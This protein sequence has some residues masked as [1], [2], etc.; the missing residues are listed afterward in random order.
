MKELTGLSEV[1]E[2]K[3]RV[4]RRSHGVS[5]GRTRSLCHFFFFFLF[6][7]LFFF[8]LFLLLNKCEGG[9][10]RLRSRRVLAG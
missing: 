7:F 5:A 6:F 2:E 3:Q 10:Q 8:F 4:T 9:F 1:A